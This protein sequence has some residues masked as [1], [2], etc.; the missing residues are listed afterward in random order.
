MHPL[1]AQVIAREVRAVARAM[2]IVDDRVAGWEM[3]L[4]ELFPHTSI[5]P[6]DDAS[7]TA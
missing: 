5:P 2:R 3:L 6:S 7:T 1:A 4:R